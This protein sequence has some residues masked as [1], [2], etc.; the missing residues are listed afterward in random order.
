[1]SRSFRIVLFLLVAGLAVGGYF[2]YEHYRAAPSSRQPGSPDNPNAGQPAGKLVVLVVF[3]QMRG[4]YIARWG[5]YFS[6]G[7]FERAKRDG[8][9]YSNV[10]IPYACTST[11]PGHASLATG[12]PPAVTGI[13]E[14]EW[15]DRK[16]GER[17]Y[18]CQPTRP[19]ELVPPLPAGGQKPTRGADTGFSPERLLAE[20]VGDRLK[21][22]TGG[23]GRVFSLSIKDRTA[24]LMGGKKPDGV[25][26]F[27][28]RD[29][30]F[31]TGAFYR[32]Q[33]LPW[34]GVFDAGKP[35]NGW[36]GQKWDRLR[37][38]LDYAKIT[39]SADD[40]AG[41]AV[42]FNGQ[43]RT[44]PHPFMGKLSKP[45]KAY[46]EAVECSPAGNELLLEFAKKAINGE[47]LGQQ[48]TTDLLC[49]SFSS[50]DMVGHQW[51]PDSWEVFDVTLRADKVV[52]D[53]LDFLDTAVGKDRYTVV[54]SADHGVCPLP[55][56]KKF[57]TA[58]RLPVNDVLVPLGKALDEKFG[59]PADGPTRWFEATDAKDQD[60]VWPWVYLHHRAILARGLKP[61]D[62]AEYARDWLAGRDDFETAFTGAQLE[63]TEFPAGSFGAKAKLAYHPDR[64]GDVIVIPK[65]GVLVTGYSGGTNHGSPQPYDSHVPVLAVG[66]GIPALGK[67][68]KKVSSL[69]VAPI[70]AKSLGIDA[71]KDAVEKAPF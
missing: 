35:A 37:P 62:V 2:A 48:K 26:C 45:E 13:I 59:V 38:D 66:A 32:E 11:G 10:E 20:T 12:A 57:P 58:R 28:T 63:R 30:M 17:V 40:A 51:G 47:N 70:L 60:R 15:W 3:D 19:Y 46:Y 5:E 18:C 4:D 67:Q 64:C 43:G 8:V 33:A 36:F 71:P 21:D 69:I 31:H 9:W 39:G 25:Y 1:M 49:L 52:A 29:G 56:Q 41:E 54:L 61:E 7:G 23:K 50:T 68:D 42:G 14:N 44:F 65:P 27:D 16:A 24:V 6:P 53:L 55:E 22:A 34:V